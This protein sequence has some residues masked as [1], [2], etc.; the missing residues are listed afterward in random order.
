MRPRAAA[1]N[2]DRAG[3]ARPS[4]S[5]SRTA[6]SWRA[7]RLMPRSR[8]LTDRG[9]TPAAL[10]SS[11]CVSWA[12][13]RS[14]RSSPANPE[15]ACSAMTAA[16]PPTALSP[17]AAQRTARQ[18]PAPR[19]PRPGARTTIP[20]TRPA[21]SPGPQ[22][23]P[24]PQPGVGT[25]RPATGAV[26]PVCP[27]TW[28][29]CLPAP[30]AGAILWVSCGP[31]RDDHT[32]PRPEQGHRQ[33]SRAG[34]LEQPGEKGLSGPCPAHTRAARL[35]MGVRIPRGPQHF[36]GEFEADA[37]S[38]KDPGPSLSMTGGGQ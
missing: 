5:A 37:E 31:L 28:S 3:S 11:A 7:V 16:S 38:T 1:T 2:S 24:R 27:G 18:G 20:G 6:V 9:L 30:P 10:A 19:L 13:A 26:R 17:P 14:C 35:F 25:P 21:R 33:P 34:R 23:P 4:A 32:G 22:P 8:S 29:R 12:S 15:V 36:P